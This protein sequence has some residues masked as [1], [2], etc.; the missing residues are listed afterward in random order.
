M[1]PNRILTIASVAVGIAIFVTAGF[2]LLGMNR[3][4]TP[5]EIA[6]PAQPAA[7]PVVATVTPIPTPVATEA[8]AAAED[9]L[10]SADGHT[11]LAN[12]A[13]RMLMRQD[14]SVVEQVAEVFKL[15][16]VERTRG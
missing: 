7:A 16:S 9:F 8:E 3:S 14:P 2:I 13:F 6:S 11:V 12:S 5:P 1:H 15:T 10:H 4:G